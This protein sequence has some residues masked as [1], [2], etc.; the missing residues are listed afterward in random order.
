MNDT[1]LRVLLVE[2]NKKHSRSVVEELQRRLGADTTVV[3]TGEDA[4]A[5]LHS[6]T[7]DIAVVDFRLPDTDGMSLLRSLQ[8]Q[9]LDIPVVMVTG[10]GDTELAVRAL[11]AGAYDY[12]VKG[13][14]LDFVRQLP[15]AI[16]DAVKSFTHEH[17]Q[18]TLLHELQEETQQLLVLAIADDLTSLYNRRHL[19]TVL[20]SEFSRARRHNRLLTAMM[21]DIDGLKAINTRYGHLCGSRLIRHVASLLAKLVR[22]S[23]QGFRYGGDEFLFLLP[24]TAEEGA[25]ALGRRLCRTVAESTLEFQGESLKTSI[26]I[27]TATLQNDN[28]PTSEA[29]IG[30]ADRA[31]FEAK[32]RGGNTVVP[33]G[34]LQLD[35]DVSR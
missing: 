16:E 15:E 20:P 35:G 6:D 25:V 28:Y 22:I 2:D 9:E 3:T 13:R 27:G 8:E 23:D 14:N 34:D 4:L 5:H 31:L 1:S 30:A 19:L 33:A 17:E 32:D 24:E 12:V 18:Q 10:V 21:T 11:K 7:F 29:L 26:S